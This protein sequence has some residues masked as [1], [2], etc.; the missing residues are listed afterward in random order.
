MMMHLFFAF[1]AHASGFS[2]DAFL[3]PALPC[4][5]TGTKRH[6]R[7]AFGAADYHLRGSRRPNLRG[8]TPSAFVRAYYARVAALV[9]RR[10]EGRLRVA[11]SR[12]AI[13]PSL[14]NP[15]VGTLPAAPSAPVH[16]PSPFGARQPG[17]IGSTRA[18][19]VSSGSSPAPAD[20]SRRLTLARAL[21]SI[22]D[23]WPLQSGKHLKA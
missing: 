2:Q 7:M 11:A 17:R 8:G 3:L 20:I 12:R 13:A 1:H 18:P 4:R 10:R 5:R 14:P 6:S 15:P 22:G 23:T 21:L 9:A 19:G 16:R